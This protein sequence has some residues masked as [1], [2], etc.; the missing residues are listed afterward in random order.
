M[1]PGGIPNKVLNSEALPQGPNLFPFIYRKGNPFHIHTIGIL[2]D[3]NQFQKYHLKTTLDWNT[4]HLD[5]NIL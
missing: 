4:E 3:V 1:V 5:T 2:H